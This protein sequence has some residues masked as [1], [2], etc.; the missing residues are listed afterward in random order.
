MPVLMINPVML[1][2]PGIGGVGLGVT[3]EKREELL[4][5]IDGAR[6]GPGVI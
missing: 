1:A 4:E 5:E 2:D 6:V 3:E